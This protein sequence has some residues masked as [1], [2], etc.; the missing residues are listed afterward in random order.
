VPVL[1]RF[2][3]YIDPTSGFWRTGTQRGNVVVGTDNT[4]WTDLPD[5]DIEPAV[6]FLRGYQVHYEE[7]RG[8]WERVDE[9]LVQIPVA[10][11]HGCTEAWALAAAMLRDHFGLVERDDDGGRDPREHRGEEPAFAEI[12]VD[13]R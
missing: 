8:R 6:R 5:S 1:E 9:L 10:T 3:T 2:V 13:V 4:T 7:I 11:P 12:R